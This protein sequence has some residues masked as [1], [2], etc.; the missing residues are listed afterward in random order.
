MGSSLC[1]VLCPGG[2]N[3]SHM[4]RNVIKSWI[5]CWE[6]QDT[7]EIEMTGWLAGI[8][9]QTAAKTGGTASCTNMKQTRKFNG[10]DNGDSNLLI[11]VTKAGAADEDEY[12]FKCGETG[13]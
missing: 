11:M 7:I 10:A 4:F 3:I 12:T 1:S 6:K 2:I 8:Q 5:L 9:K 13:R